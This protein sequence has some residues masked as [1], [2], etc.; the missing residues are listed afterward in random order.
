M[1]GLSLSSGYPRPTAQTLDF[2]SSSVQAAEALTSVEKGSL[3]KERRTKLST[4]QSVWGRP[5]SPSQTQ[6]GYNVL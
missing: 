4:G 6:V 3:S 2:F 1:E 5:V